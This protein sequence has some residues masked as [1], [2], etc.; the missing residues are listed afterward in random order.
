MLSDRCK[1]MV[2]GALRKMGLH[3]AIVNLGEVRIKESI[4]KQQREE[5]KITLHECGLELMN[6]K[7]AML[8][9]DVKNLIVEMINSDDDLPKIN[10]S[11]YL[12]QRLNCNYIYLSNLFSKKEGTTLKN[13]ILQHKIDRVKQLILCDELNLTDIAWKLNYSSVGHLSTQF[14]KITGATPSLFKSIEHRE[15]TVLAN[16]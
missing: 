5:I 13:F 11:L 2:S 8:I 1:Q 6:D 10:F 12:S 9:E 4:T 15:Q 7:E 3:F 16:Q 14:L